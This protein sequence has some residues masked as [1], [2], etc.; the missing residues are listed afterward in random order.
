MM[1]MFIAF[2]IFVLATELPLLQELL[3][4]NSLTIGSWL[5]LGAIASVVIVAMEIYKRV[6]RDKPAPP[7][8]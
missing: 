5:A 8:I 7:L 6:R 3:R 4:T 2:G 1:G